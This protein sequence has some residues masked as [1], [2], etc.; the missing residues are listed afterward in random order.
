MCQIGKQVEVVVLRRLLTEWVIINIEN[1]FH[2]FT[3]SKVNVRIV[4]HRD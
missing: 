2:N 3:I 4:G 1:I